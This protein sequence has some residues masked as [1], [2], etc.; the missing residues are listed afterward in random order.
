MMT[1][2]EIL[3]YIWELVTASDIN[4]LNG[5][6]YKNTRPTDS[7]LDDCVISV[8]SGQNA[9][10]LQSGGLYIKIFYADIFMN[11]T[12]YENEIKA[13]DYE[14]LLINFSNTL[15]K[16]NSFA[17]DI[18]SRETYT[19]RVQDTNVSSIKQHYAIL[20]INFKKLTK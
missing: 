4:L 9:K 12:Y 13:D 20:K 6:V 19:E 5:G 3:T 10:F 15:I 11:N 18:E 8:I 17:F 16:D 14:K 1:Q 7:A 2:N